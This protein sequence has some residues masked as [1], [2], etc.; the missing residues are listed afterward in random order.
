MHTF[1]FFLNKDIL[2]LYKHLFKIKERNASESM[3]INRVD[4]VGNTV[5]QWVVR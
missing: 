5:L 3:A 4:T 2:V 1:M